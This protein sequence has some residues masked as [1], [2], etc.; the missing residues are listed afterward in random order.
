MLA[1]IIQTKLKGVTVM[2]TVIALVVLMI[3]FSCGM[4][5]YTKV[6]RTGIREESL[7]ASLG[8]KA[9]ADSLV[10]CPIPSNEDMIFRKNDLTFELKYLSDQAYP[11]MKVLS[12]TVRDELGKPIGEEWRLIPEGHEQ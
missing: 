4:V 7:R 1:K 12:I 10:A 2:E 6:L 3:S 9:L 5:I 8:L 11:G